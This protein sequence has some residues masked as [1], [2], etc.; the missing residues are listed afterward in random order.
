MASVSYDAQ[1]AVNGIVS[2]INN[3][4]KKLAARFGGYEEVNPAYTMG[5]MPD[6]TQGTYVYTNLVNKRNQFNSDYYA[7]ISNPGM[8][9]KT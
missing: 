9:D 3:N 1:Q 2:T 8:I 5:T 6:K 4:I 7:S